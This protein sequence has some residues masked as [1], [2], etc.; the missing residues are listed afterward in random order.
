MAQGGIISVNIEKLAAELLAQVPTA[1]DRQRLIG[2]LG[3]AALN[4]W[5]LQA[6]RELRSTSRDYV[7]ALQLAVTDK[8]ATVTLAGE[9]PNLVENGFAG[10]DMR[11]WML[12]KSA[13]RGKRGRYLVIPLQHGTPG[14]AGRNVGP[15]M[16]VSIY[17]A[18]KK[19]APSLSRPGGG[20]KY[21]GRLG[22]QSRGVNE[23]AR[24]ILQTKARPWHASSIYGGMI[25]EQKTHA[26]ATQTSGYKTFR[27][28][29]E[30][31]IRGARDASGAALQHWH[32]PGI[33]AKLLARKTEDFV[34]RTAASMLLGST[35]PK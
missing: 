29:S 21:G 16:P 32:H 1:D 31:V 4:F 20:V 28:I 14:T 6:Q 18:A 33:R 3:T 10:G 35:R 19:L 27:T 24:S 25:R 34:V 2:S 7:Q 11:K 8:S 22:P 15:V 23:Q 30:S 17:N 13:K 9:L 5:K 26:R 12:G